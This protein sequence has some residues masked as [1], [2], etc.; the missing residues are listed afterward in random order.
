MSYGAVP[1]S[2]GV[3]RVP[4][5]SLPY[6]VHVVGCRPFCASPHM[7]HHFLL[8]CSHHV[9][10]NRA[11]CPTSMTCFSLIDALL[12]QRSTDELFIVAVEGCSG[13]TEPSPTLARKR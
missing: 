13:N 11:N 8:R 1:K 10:S 6:P 9:E 5:A 7:I 3:N 4:A 2:R 12:L